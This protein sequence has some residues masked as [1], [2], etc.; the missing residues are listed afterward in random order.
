MKLDVTDRVVDIPKILILGAPRS[1][2]TLINGIICNNNCTYPQLP[3][4]T[5]I[6]Q[7][8]KH[9]NDFIL[10]SDS[11]RFNAYGK[12][13]KTLVSHYQV[14]VDSLINNAL[15]SFEYESSKWLVMKDPELT[16]LPDEI[17]KFFGS[18]SKVVG[19]VRDPRN[20][21]VSFRNVLHK[22]RAS[23]FNTF[24]KN[25]DFNSF[26][27][28]SESLIERK[29][30]IESVFNYYWRLHNSDLYK[31]GGVHIVK[32]ENILSKDEKEFKNLEKYLGFDLDNTGFGTPLYEFDP[33]DYTYS[34]NY[35]KSIAQP[36]SDYKKS[37]S[38]T[39]ARK[40]E[41]VFSGLNN[42]YN[43]W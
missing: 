34:S 30:L 25:L 35:G 4:C 9:C 22:K 32:Y 40:I 39:L 13:A 17:H 15:M 43:W 24:L 12:D 26:S 11:A 18:A 1:G 37:L 27:K 14:L 2:T 3:E 28:I 19:V 7:L 36:N 41:N 38:R 29:L 21:I 16:L 6:T 23:L 5:Y 10:F 33:N 8:I 42:V 31:S 20:V